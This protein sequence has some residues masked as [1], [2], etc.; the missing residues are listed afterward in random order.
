[1]IEQ[2]RVVGAAARAK[3]QALVVECMALQP[4]LQS[5]LTEE[6]HLEGWQPTPIPGAV[7]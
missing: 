5:Q 6:N 4:A 3:S 2:I 7:R 1:M